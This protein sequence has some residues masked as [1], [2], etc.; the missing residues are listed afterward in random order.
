MPISQGLVGPATN[1]GANAQLPQRMGQLGDAIVSQLHGRFYEQA[2]RG[3]VFFSG[4]TAV[5]ALSANTITTTATTTPILGIWNPLSSTVNCAILQAHLNLFINNLTSGAAPGALIWHVSTG[6][7]A[8]STGNLPFNAKTLT[9]SGSQAKGFA[10]S[11]ALTGLTNGLVPAFGSQLPTPAGVTYGTL[12]GTVLHQSYSEREDF[13]GSLIVPPGAVLALLNTTSSTVFSAV[14][15]L[16]WE[17]V[18]L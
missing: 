5:V 6:N 8:I 3:N 9:Q 1:S 18:P 12:P 7:S 4:H 11:V 14:G 15:R 13:D 10:G 16:V 2:Y 17:E